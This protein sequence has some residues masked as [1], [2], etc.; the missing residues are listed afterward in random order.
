MH[1]LTFHLL[2]PALGVVIAALMFVPLAAVHVGARSAPPEPLFVAHTALTHSQVVLSLL[3][4]SKE[5][6]SVIAQNNGAAPA[7]VALDLYTPGGIYIPSASIIDTAVPVGATR[8][9]AQAV[10]SGLVPGF[11]G[12]GILSSDQ[13]V[14]ALLV[15]DIESALGQKSYSIHSSSPAGASLVTLPY[16]AN[17]VNGVYNTRISIANSGTTTA[18]VTLV[19]SFVD[20]TRSPVTDSG[21]GGNGCTAG[22]PVPVGG[23]VAFAPNTVDG[24][25]AMPSQT[26]N[27]LMAA[28]VTATGAPVTVAVDAYLSG[29]PRKLASYDGF[30]VDT[31]NP[32]ASDTGTTIAIPLALKTA[33]GY[34]S[35]VLL[36][37]PNAT[38]AHATI[39]YRDTSGHSY[40]VPLLVAANGAATHSVYSD[41]VV[42]VG[43]V[44]AATVTAD[45]PLAAVLFRSKMTTAGSF[46]DEDLYSAVNGVPVVR[47]ATSAKLPLIFRRAYRAGSNAGYNTWVSVSVADGGAANLTITAVNDTQNA[48]PECSAPATYTATRTISGSFIFYQNLDDASANGFG[49]LP[50]CFW[51]GMTISSD[52]PIIAIANATNDLYAGDNDGTYNAFSP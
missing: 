25:V 21:P 3:P 35:Q 33:D 26:T 51:G 34:Y 10:N 28:T 18:C 16:V 15:R 41:N 6:T 47:A 31:A 49:T 36:S 44:G 46:V 50:S 14:N 23:Q 40:A 30:V 8:T 17:A 22:Y 24:A 4:N 2:L 42:P 45:Q 29:G 9:F 37:N 13:P 27:G 48:A 38:A 52:R 43:F 20:G 12:V 11:R 5:N 19:Y 7:T 39:T 32:A 1:R